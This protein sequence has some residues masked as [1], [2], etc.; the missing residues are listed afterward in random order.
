MSSSSVDKFPIFF[1][2]P[3]Y[4][5]P[6]SEKS[7]PSVLIPS[8]INPLH[9][10][11][12]DLRTILIFSYHLHLNIFKWHFALRRTYQNPVCTLPLPHTCSMPR[13]SVL[14]IYASRSVVWLTVH[15]NSV[16]IRSQLHVTYVLSNSV[17]IRS[18]LHVTYVLSFIS[19]LQVA[20][21]V[22]G[23]HVSIIRS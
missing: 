5:F 19:P 18:Q 22:S 4:P 13:P 8:Q 17:L 11:P 20:Q 1:M 3:E 16:W 7:P 21:H 6:W 12:T 23:N 14:T 15:R 2:E 10:F 9:A